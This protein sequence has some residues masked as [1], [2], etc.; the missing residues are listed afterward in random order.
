MMST[1]RQLVWEQIRAER[2]ATIAHQLARYALAI[3]YEDL[4]TD[5]IHQAKR[6]LLDTLGCALGALDAPGYKIL[7]DFLEAQGGTEE[8][9]VF[10]S[11]MR[12]SASNVALINS[13][14][15]RFLDFNDLGGG[16]HNSDALPSL[17]A[18]AEREGSSGE[19]LLLAIVI[20][21]ELGARFR[22]SVTQLTGPDGVRRI[23][24]EER[25]WTSDIRAGV[26]QSPAL[27]RLL[28]MTEEQIAN[29][30]G[31]SATHAL[32]LG[33]LDGH[34]EE[35]TMAKNLRFGWAAHDAMLGCFLA[36]RGFTGPVEV[37][38][39]PVGMKGAIFRDD[40]DLPQLTD[41]SDWKI[42]D[43][44]FKTLA[45]N[46]TSHAHLQATINIVTRE[47]LKP[48]DI[49]RI[50]IRTSVRDLRHTTSPPKRYPRNAESA[51]HSSHYG[52]AIA[53][54]ERDF[55]PSAID[56]SKFTD[57][58]VLDLIDRT[59]VE[60]DPDL[61]FFQGESHIITRDGR[62]FRERVDPAPGMGA[63]GSSDDE[64]ERKFRGLAEGRISSGKVEQ[65]VRSC[66]ELDEL[67]SVQPLIDAMVA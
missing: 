22:E 66:W 34:R 23:S 47:D 35:A 52:T 4:P 28:G 48:E 8:A 46:V 5:V 59:I 42:R 30:I 37:V 24:L 18:L 45:A 3:R 26:T 11:G 25:G 67:R 7:H 14:L 17:L 2:R 1:R 55:G 21:Y 39:S 41:F 40:I 33:I 38:E 65:L 32:P 10:G 12:T 60:G 13:F 49:E 63:E 57:P 56:P 54:I 50:R 64:L 19:D 16:G 58:L 20:S 43:V 51:D 36:Q 15:V 9:T 44:R 27:G 61:G 62:E 31:I 6:C 29:A 53:I